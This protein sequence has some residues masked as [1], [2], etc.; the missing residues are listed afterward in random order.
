MLSNKAEVEVLEEIG[1]FG[2]VCKGLG[3]LLVNL[4]EVFLPELDH[5]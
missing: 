3:S 5:A 1:V 4:G 2:R